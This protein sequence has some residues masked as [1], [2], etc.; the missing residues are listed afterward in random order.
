MIIITSLERSNARLKKPVKNAA[1]QS[2]SKKPAAA[3]VNIKI[4]IA[5]I[6]SPKILWKNNLGL[7]IRVIKP[8]LSPHLRAIIL[9]AIWKSCLSLVVR[10]TVVLATPGKPFL[11]L[12]YIHSSTNLSIKS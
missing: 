1:E 5:A 7:C 4:V 8:L 2:Q 9:L 11:F 3:R 12:S 6:I 10:L